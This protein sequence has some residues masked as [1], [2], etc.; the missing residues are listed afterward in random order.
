MTP[1]SESRSDVIKAESENKAIQVATVGQRMT[2]IYTG[3]APLGMLEQGDRELVLLQ[4]KRL[5]VV[6]HGRKTEQLDEVV[7]GE[8]EKALAVDTADLDRD[9][10]PEIY[11]TVMQEE[12]LVSQVWEFK[13]QHLVKTADELPYYFRVLTDAQGRRIVYTQQIGL[14]E[15]F[16]GPV[17][18]LK[19]GPKGYELQNS[20]KLPRFGHIFNFNRFTDSEGKPLLVV[21]HPDG[22]LMVFTESGE[23]LW[24]SNDKYGGSEVYF[25]R[26]DLQNMKNTGTATRKVFLEQR[27][28]VRN[29]SE[30]IVPQNSGFWVVGNSRSYSK[31]AVHAFAWTCVGLEE[32]WHTKVSRR[33]ICQII[34][35]MNLA[36]NLY[37]LR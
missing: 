20:L 28:I 8:N 23:E 6:R 21:L 2:G 13:K 22:F 37:S 19:K 11:V 14:N 25:S 10:Q 36:T 35:W 32:R 9:G 18:E 3:I 4:D 5:Q 1:S 34:T 26:S 15:D 12:R 17:S 16:Y 27:I 24:R 30:I 7:F 29:N 33:T 31:S